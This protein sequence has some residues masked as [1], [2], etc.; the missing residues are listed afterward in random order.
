VLLYYFNRELFVIIR[1]GGINLTSFKYVPVFRYRTQER[2]ALNSTP[3]SSKILPLIEIVTKKPTSKSKNDSIDQLLKDFADSNTNV[4]IDIPMYIKLNNS[5]LKTVRDFLTP[6]LADPNKRIEILTDPRLAKN[7]KIIP[8]ITYNPNSP[9]TKGYLT[10]QEKHLRNYYNQIAF[11]IYPK[12]FNDSIYEL[13]GLLESGDIILL[14]IDES[15]HSH[16]ANRKMYKKVQEI[17]TSNDCKCV[18]I[19][20]AI[21][22]ALTNVDL[23]HGKI[24]QEADNSLLTDYKS[25][26]FSAFGDY[27][28][29]KK[30]NLQRG[31]RISPGYI[32]YSWED[33]SYYGFKGVIEQADTF[34]SIVAPS[35]ISS[36]V[37]KEY[38]S[39]H[40]K[41]CFGCGTID[42]IQKKVKKGNSQPEWKGFACSHY[43]YTMEEFL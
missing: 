26:G 17:A 22:R 29:I 35:V 9:F 12:Y 43:L 7:E 18:L 13:T 5:T 11:R 36:K 38:N 20:S 28:G 8:V 34:V 31:G 3:I 25:L 2:K 32:M 10:S 23:D 40:H 42:R 19:R 6:V 39:N 30:D 21:P 33:N 41:N 1:N 16:P 24:I 15:P 37:W 4:M 27:C 14:D